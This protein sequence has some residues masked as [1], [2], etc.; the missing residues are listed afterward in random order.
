MPGLR[1]F[2]LL[3]CVAASAHAQTTAFEGRTVV[4]VQYSP[5]SVLSEADLAA[6]QPVKKGE[7]LRADDV[8]RAIDGLFATG[9]FSDIRA[10]AE[11]S[12]TGVTVR[13]VTTPRY[14]LGGVDVEGK[15]ALPPNRGELHS[16]TQLTLGSPFKEEDLTNAVNSVKRLLTSNGLYDAQVTPDVR[17]DEDGQQV[18]I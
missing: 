1:G 16:N 15:V 3:L 17:R 14:F 2:V 4:D 5:A 13:F 7:P 8:A 6:V 18:F 9:R 10:E 12:G 11:P